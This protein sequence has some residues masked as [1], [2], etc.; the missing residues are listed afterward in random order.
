M[1]LAVLG[2]GGNIGDTQSL[3]A[4]AI[5]QLVR[6]PGIKVEVVSALYKTPPWGKT[7]QPPFLN[8]AVRIDTR[9]TPQALLDAVL[10]V[11]KG[12]GRERAERWGPRT[13]DIDI[14]VY[15]GETVDEPGLHIPHPRLTERAFALAPLVDVMPQAEIS[16]RPA[17]EWLVLSDQAG[18]E[19]IAEA[20]WH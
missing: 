20:G 17:K 1:T 14:L 7:D 10:A 6:H 16:G 15:G 5:R 11:E 12:L 18:M 2:L 9:L 19:R 13:I 8:A 3:M 4:A